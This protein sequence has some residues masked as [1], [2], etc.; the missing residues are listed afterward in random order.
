MKDN[1]EFD[2]VSRK[3]CPNDELCLDIGC[4]KLCRCE[5]CSRYKDCEVRIQDEEALK[6]IPSKKTV[7]WYLNS[8]GLL[9]YPAVIIVDYFGHCIACSVGYALMS[10]GTDRVDSVLVTESYAELKLASPA[11]L[12]DYSTPY[13][14]I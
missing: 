7:S 9:G 6:K 4:L 13:K 14:T 11:V 5:H 12:S 10:Y 2:C 3:E 1:C 8:F